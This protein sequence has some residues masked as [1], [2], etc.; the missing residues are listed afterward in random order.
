MQTIA[1]V[2]STDRAYD[3]TLAGIENIDGRACYHL[4]LRPLRDASLYPLRNVW[5]DTGS[6]DVVQLTYQQPFN[7][8]T[9][10]V[11]YRFAPVGSSGT[12]TI[13]HI[14]AQSQR[15]RVSEDLHDIKFPASEPAEDFTP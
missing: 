7:V 8:T 6:F 12:W 3:V 1:T 2:T 5:V 10:M 14:E 15:E 13:V 11:E 9:A 4:V